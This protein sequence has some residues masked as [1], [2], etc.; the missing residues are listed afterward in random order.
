MFL[1]CNLLGCSK[2]NI[3][4]PYGFLNLRIEGQ[5][6]DI[7]WETV[8]AK[9]IDTLGNADLEAT[10]YYFDR[11]NIHLKNITGLG[12]VNPLTLM[13]FY[14]TDGL[15]FQPYAISGTLSITEISDKAIRGTF[16]LYLD[17]NFNGASGRRITGD[18]GIINAK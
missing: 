1:I 9:W 10:S 11:C 4:K 16:N 6:E 15:D 8:I 18:F 3:T 17:N 5:E 13:Q 14:Y 2:E 7:K 12:N